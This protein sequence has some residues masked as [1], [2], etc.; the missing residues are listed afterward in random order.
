MTARFTA[1]A[2]A[3]L[4][5]LG[6]AAPRAAAAQSR[7]QTIED[8]A[9]MLSDGT[10]PEQVLRRLESTGSCVSFVVN[11]RAVERLT[12]AGADSG[13]I[14]RLRDVCYEGTEL[15]VTTEPAGAEVIIDGRTVGKSPYRTPEEP[16]VM[17]TVQ[18]R[19]G[20]WLRS[21]KQ[22]QMI[23]QDQRTRIH[24]EV[25]QD[26]IA[27]P[28]RRTE[29]DFGEQFGLLEGWQSRI[30]KPELPAPP[31]GW[32]KTKR[33]LIGAAVFGGAAYA[34]GTTQ[35]Q[36]V[37]PAYTVEGQT[38]PE[39]NLGVDPNCAGGMAAGGALGGA[40]LSAGWAKMRH[41]G[42]VRSYESAK[43]NFG[44]TLQAWEDAKRREQNA[45]L[46]THPRVREAMA[47]QATRLAPEEDRI[48]EQNQ[49]I[50]DRNRALT[51]QALVQRE[52]PTPHLAARERAAEAFLADVDTAIPRA[53]APRPKAVAV[54]IG[55]TS[56]SKRDVPAV[57]YATRDAQ[58]IRR[59]LIEALGF[60]NDHIIFEQDAT[61]TTLRAV[62]G[63]ETNERG[64]LYE[65]A[66]FAGQGGD[67]AEVFVFYSG[68]GAPGTNDK[69]GYLVPTDADPNRMELQGYSMAQLYR[70]LA[71]LPA[72]SV[73][74]VLDACF[75]GGS[76]RGQLIKG[77]SG[78]LLR[79]DNLFLGV[80]NGNLFA[81][82]ESD[83]IS[84]WYEE[85]KH[86]LFT[87]YFLKGLQGAADADANAEI[88]AKEMDDYLLAAVR[89]RASLKGRE[90]R[91]VFVG[92]DP[93]R[94][95]AA[96]QAATV[97]AGER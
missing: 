14:A 56:Y 63:T 46:A 19:K 78:G 80:E 69:N 1:A 68:H 32:S 25:P 12:R 20:A 28:R 33:M 2:A 67:S 70:N 92:R 42:H 13:F 95:I 86:G 22:A 7:P 40:L 52:R 96:L 88:T 64:R 26:T 73:T 38:Y 3:T 65:Q 60:S 21:T 24:F 90:Q 61:L 81:A 97:K 82:A 16:G 84:S 53:R 15:L 58:A 89:P 5:A 31:K 94:V 79:L 41:G 29:R 51:G 71:K 91:P 45:W 36:V 85:K 49:R 30:P 75:S 11:Q 9:L 47:E 66:A 37:D 8:I 55:N 39:T 72:K 34:V 62:F 6:A 87:Y 57:E 10:R 27:W 93:S 59:Y 17:H 4:V 35:C 23:E 77:A 44:A 50:L 76:D 83:Q 74:L 48:R 54:V 43:R 18:V